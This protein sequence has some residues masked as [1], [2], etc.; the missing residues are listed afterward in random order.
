MG[1]ILTI[2]RETGVIDES[3]LTQLPE[4]RW[5]DLVELKNSKCR[6]RTKNSGVKQSY[7][8]Y[9]NNLFADSLKIKRQGDNLYFWMIYRR[10]LVCLKYPTPI[11]MISPNTANFVSF[12]RK[13]ESKNNLYKKEVAT[14]QIQDSLKMTPE[15]VKTKLEEV[16]KWIESTLRDTTSM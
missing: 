4:N 9:V 2:V 3:S 8:P 1:E 13:I 12:I 11:S 10:R 14:K 5:I 7:H 6:I 16:K 15:E